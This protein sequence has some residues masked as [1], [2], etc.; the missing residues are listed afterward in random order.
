MPQRDRVLQGLQER[1]IGAAIHYPQALHLTGAMQDL[2]HR[3]GDFPVAEAAAQE[4]L[5][6]P[7]FPQ[8]SV[9]QQEAV[10]E[11]LAQALR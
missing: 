9:G 5:S 7:L 10:V 3:A 11:A 1:G 8:I 2:G 4:I 6:L